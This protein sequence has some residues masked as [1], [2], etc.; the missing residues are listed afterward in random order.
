MNHLILPKVTVL[1]PVYNGERFLR[2]AIESILNQTFT[3]FE[4]LIINDGSTDRSVEIINSYKDPRIRLVHNE[5]N[6]GLVPTLN[7]GLDLSRGQYIARMDCDDISLPDRLQ[8]QVAYMDA[9]SDIDICGTWFRHFGK[10][11]ES[12]IFLPENHEDIKCGLLFYTPMAHP[13]III[14]KNKLLGNN[15]YYDPTYNNA[16]DYELWVRSLEY[17]KFHNIGKTLLLYRLHDKQ[18]GCREYDKQLTSSR[19]VWKIQLKNLLI[20]PTEEDLDMHQSL[21]TGISEQNEDFLTKV[22]K[23]LYMLQSANKKL[24][25]YSDMAFE[26][27]I[28]ERWIKCCYKVYGFSAPC[29]MKLC[30]SVIFKE[31]ENK[32]SIILKFLFINISQKIRSHLFKLPHGVRFPQKKTC[33][34]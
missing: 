23:W 16:E 32:Y 12:T 17:L 18:V 10:T 3:D 7:K 24:R 30:S 31:T 33:R 1:M 27:L 5:R 8:K 9:N 11:G 29:I 19:M 6:I 25:F 26:H 22:E 14:R 20:T 15:L 28:H 2:E 4:F 21:C 13:S 34:K